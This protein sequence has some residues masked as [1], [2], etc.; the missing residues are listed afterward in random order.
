[1]LCLKLSEKM[2]KE[3]PPQKFRE[4]V[5]QC[6]FSFDAGEGDEK[7]LVALLMKQLALSSK[8]VKR[9]LEYAQK[10]WEEREELD[11]RIANRSQEYALE[12]IHKVER[13]VLRMSLFALLHEKELSPKI[14][15]SEAL[16]ITRKFSTK[17]GSQFVNVIL[18]EEWKNSLGVPLSPQEEPQPQ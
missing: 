1:M 12:R 10:I 6:L 2:E 18:D 17:E 3:L 15:I 7:G 16:R 13:T 14:V 9:G 5:F 11:A 8:Y 4:V